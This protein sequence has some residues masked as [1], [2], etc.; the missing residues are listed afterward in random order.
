V[1]FAGVATVAL[2]GYM[3]GVENRALARSE[4][5]AVFVAGDAIKEGTTAEDAVGRRL[6][7]TK[8][9]PRLA[10]VDGTIAS[11]EDIRGKVATTD[12]VK[13]EQIVTNRFSTARNPT[14]IDIPEGRQ[15]MSVQ[16]GPQPGVA[17]YVR[18]GDH[19]SVI[20]QAAKADATGDVRVQYLM[21]DIQVLAVGEYTAEGDEAAQEGVGG[22]PT[23]LLTLAVTPA[24]AEKLA[25]A[26]LR[27]EVYFTLLPPG[28]RPQD[29]PG[30][31][32][33]DLFS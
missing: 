29:T 8:E 4:P 22:A 26:V 19:I 2:F 21:Q 9:L 7:V 31:T 6:I 30:R 27:G 13:G 32:A 14:V 12:I 23:I 5:V 25:Y 28:Q 1:V 16:L 10:V 20:A 11:L 15:A 3:R 24:E 33:N 17:G 18:P